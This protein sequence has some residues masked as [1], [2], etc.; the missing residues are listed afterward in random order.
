MLGLVKSSLEL[1]VQHSEPDREIPQP[2]NK[3][4]D[5]TYSYKAIFYYQIAILLGLERCLAVRIL[6][7]H[8]QR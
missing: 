8:V 5:R 1:L 3:I 2:Q 4:L 6:E 7:G